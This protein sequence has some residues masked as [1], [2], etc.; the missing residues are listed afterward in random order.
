MA[1]KL[2]LRQFLL[3]QIEHKV[4]LENSDGDRQIRC[5]FVQLQASIFEPCVK[6]VNI[7]VDKVVNSRRSGGTA[8]GVRNRYRI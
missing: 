5:D 2:P 6:R 4:D 1:K 8:R 3:N 7:L